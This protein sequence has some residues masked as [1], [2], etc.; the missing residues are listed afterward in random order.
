[1]KHRSLHDLPNPYDYSNP[2]KEDRLFF[3]RDEELGD[4]DYY[5]LQ[6]KRTNNPIHLAFIGDR[7]SGK[8]SFLN[9]T[10]IYAKKM[11][12]AQSGSI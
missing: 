7:A 10:E 9:I 8:T 5:L 12:S 3:G 2:V 4:V 1:M 11:T 6:A